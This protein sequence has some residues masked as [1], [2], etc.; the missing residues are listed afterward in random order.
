[1]TAVLEAALRRRSHHSRAQLPLS[2]RRRQ[3]SCRDQ[4][5][6]APRNGRQQRG[7]SPSI[8]D[9]SDAIR[10]PRP[11]P[12]GLRTRRVGR[13]AGSC[14]R[15]QPRNSLVRRLPP[16]RRSRST[17]PASI[18]VESS[19]S[20]DYSFGQG[21]G[22]EIQSRVPPANSHC[23]R[24]GIPLLGTAAHPPGADP[25]RQ[26]RAG[27]HLVEPASDRRFQI[28]GNLVA[29]AGTIGHPTNE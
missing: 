10:K 21:L 16:S 28:R 18:Y 6:A 29:A 12:G 3:L 20:P 8:G 7:A 13:I 23:G 15:K 27:P 14:H 5:A 26:T 17:S 2:E 24:R 4:S 9:S 25:D 22:R 11:S 1:M 19:I